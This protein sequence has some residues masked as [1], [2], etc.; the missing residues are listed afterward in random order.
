MMKY[1]GA[2]AGDRTMLD[3]LLPAAQALRMFVGNG[4]DSGG[5]GG[6]VCEAVE[7]AATAGATATCEMTAGAG[8]SSY[9]PV[10]VLK[11][12]PDPG[13]SAAAAWI[14]GTVASLRGA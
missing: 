6:G 14:R 3:A 11:T 13:A 8:R 7:R 4:A 12:V 2:K 5:G 10:E 1:G 9:V